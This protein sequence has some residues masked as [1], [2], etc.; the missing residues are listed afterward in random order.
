MPKSI[1][2][3]RESR[4]SPNRKPRLRCARRTDR[5]LDTGSFKTVLADFTWQ[6][7]SKNRNV[8]RIFSYY[9]FI[10]LHA[11][12]ADKE[13]LRRSKP[14]TPNKRLKTGHHYYFWWDRKRVFGTSWK[15]V[16]AHQTDSSCYSIQL[17]LIQEKKKLPKTLKIRID[18]ELRQKT[19]N[20]IL[21]YLLD[22]EIPGHDSLIDWFGIFSK[23]GP[24]EDNIHTFRRQTNSLSKSIR[25]PNIALHRIALHR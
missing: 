10:F 7:L 14:Y 9:F 8:R 21:Y 3:N 1:E 12:T 17:L 11:G 18:I 24:A 25:T 4:F 23:T 5:L 22:Q 19:S 20:S 13:C 2:S 15:F 16:L 6:R